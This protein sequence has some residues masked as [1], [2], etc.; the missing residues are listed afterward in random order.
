MYSDTWTLLC[1]VQLFFAM[2]SDTWTPPIVFIVVFDP[3]QWSL[4]DIYELA[5][6]GSE[7]P[8]CDSDRLVD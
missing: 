1:T 2:Y 4:L 7:R 5:I 8:R 6:H 3:V